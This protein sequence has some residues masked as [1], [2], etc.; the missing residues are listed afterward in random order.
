MAVKKPRKERS[1]RRQNSKLNDAEDPSLLMTQSDFQ[2]CFHLAMNDSGAVAYQ[3]AYGVDRDNAISHSYKKANQPWVIKATNDLRVHLAKSRANTAILTREEVLGLCAR[4]VRTPIS[5]V[6][7]H[8]P[9][10]IEFTTETT[11]FGT[12]KTK[13]KKISPLDA[14]KLAAQIEGWDKSGNDDPDTPLTQLLAEIIS[15]GMP[16]E[17]D[18][19][20]PQ[21][22]ELK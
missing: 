3:K 5:E 17:R 11:A 21:P 16:E 12:V 13:T 14:A 4:S 8:D 18:V 20:P 2:F 1:N 19:T 9:L 7:E 10:C 22:K 6:D 15:E